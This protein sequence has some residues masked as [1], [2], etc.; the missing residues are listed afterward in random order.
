MAPK[1]KNVSSEGSGDEEYRKKRDRNN[2]VSW[3]DN[4]CLL[5]FFMTFFSFY[6]FSYERQAVKRSRVKSKQRASETR[7]RVDE[8]KVKNRVLEESI[9]KHQKDLKFLKDLFLE[10]ARTKS[11]TLEGLNLKELLKDDS[12][13]EG[14]KNKSKSS[15]SKG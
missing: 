8:L 7:S 11:D 2:Q 14:G 4:K 6:L 10:Q 3:F 5:G 1:R 13:D 9:K 15:T 12:D